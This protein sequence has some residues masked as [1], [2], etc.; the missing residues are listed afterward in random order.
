MESTESTLRS[1]D[2]LT[3]KNWIS[4]IASLLAY[5]ANLQE[6]SATKVKWLKEHYGINEEKALEFFAVHGVLDLK[7]SN[8]WK[9]ILDKN[10]VSKEEK[11]E[12]K[13]ALGKSMDSLWQFLD[14]IQA[15]HSPN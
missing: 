14:G 6:T 3:R 13:M 11:E 8:D 15:K 10:A 7:H 1:F 2:G 12:A 4:G 9:E 5:E